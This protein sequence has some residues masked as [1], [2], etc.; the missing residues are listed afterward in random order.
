MLI[1]YPPCYFT[2]LRWNLSRL[3]LSLLPGRFP[4]RKTAHVLLKNVQALQRAFPHRDDSLL[5]KFKESLYLNTLRVNG[6]A[7]VSGSGGYHGPYYEP[8][9]LKPQST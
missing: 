2:I 4:Q 1:G 6:L 9:T 5:S 7:P 8:I 3:V